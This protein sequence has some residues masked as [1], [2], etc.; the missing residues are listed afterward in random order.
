MGPSNSAMALVSTFAP[1]PPGMPPPGPDVRYHTAEWHH[2][3]KRREWCRHCWE[4][5]IWWLVRSNGGILDYE[6]FDYVV[7]RA[8]TAAHDQR[9]VSERSCSETH[10]SAWCI[11]DKWVTADHSMVVFTTNNN[12]N[13]IKVFICYPS[14]FVCFYKFL[15]RFYWFLYVYIGFI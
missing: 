8:K 5:I 11:Y 6:S 1:L 15:Y 2:R 10:G 12:I 7:L 4:R 9:Q 13:E 3:K 14:I